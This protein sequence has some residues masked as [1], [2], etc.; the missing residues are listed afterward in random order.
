MNISERVAS[1]L[2]IRLTWS[3]WLNIWLR[4]PDGLLIEFQFKTYISQWSLTCAPLHS[5]L[6]IQNLQLSNQLSRRYKLF[7]PGYVHLRLLKMTFNWEKSQNASLFNSILFYLCNNSHIPHHIL[8]LQVDC[9]I[10]YMFNDA[11]TS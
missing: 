10:V 1:L 6:T 9:L 2:I 8:Y 5:R 11:N 3:R 4:Q 7:L